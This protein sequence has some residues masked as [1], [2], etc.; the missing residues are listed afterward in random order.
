[1]PWEVEIGTSKWVGEEFVDWDGFRGIIG[2][3]GVV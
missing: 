3:A 2:F 1:M